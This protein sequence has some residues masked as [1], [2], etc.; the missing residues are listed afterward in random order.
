MKRCLHVR[1]DVV[2]LRPGADVA[3]KHVI[4]FWS[5]VLLG[6][7]VIL[8]QTTVIRSVNPKYIHTIC[9]M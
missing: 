2:Q 5:E 1:E 3:Q 7:G 9:T 8:Q 4:H 6:D